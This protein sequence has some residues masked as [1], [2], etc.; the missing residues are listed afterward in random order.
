M[1]IKFIRLGLVAVVFL[2][3][4]TITAAAQQSS[5]SPVWKEYVYEENGF[6]IT[7]PDDPHPHK[8][9]VVRDGTA[10][11]V[12]LFKGV[13]FSVHSTTA[14][15][16]CDSVR[17][18]SDRYAKNKDAPPQNGFK[19]ISFSDVA[20]SGYTG[21]EFVQQVPNGRIDYERWVCGANRLYIFISGWSS[22]EPEP[23]DLRRILN[24]FRVI[25][26]K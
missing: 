6:A 24:S 16:K 20:G 23:K 19:A 26:T 2:H 4:L 18:Q 14:D 3:T 12:E 10:Y 21:I 1:H 7:L 5:Q 9:Q 22:G 8:S 11:R 25:P 17:E 15:P 13:F